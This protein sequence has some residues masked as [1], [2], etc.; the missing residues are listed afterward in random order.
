[1]P[2][3]RRVFPAFCAG[4]LVAAG[5]SVQPAAAADGARIFNL[6]CRT[7]HGAASTVA[8]PALTGVAG[9]RI[10]SRSD[11]AYSSALKSKGGA[12]TDAALDAYLA[13]PTQFAPGGRMITAVASPKDR[14]ALIAHLKTLR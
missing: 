8:G 1:M 2:Q 10:A 5:L 11:F 4:L 12:W 13:A 7:C 3:S 9:A 6:Q 14:A